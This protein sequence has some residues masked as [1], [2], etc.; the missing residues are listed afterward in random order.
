MMTMFFGLLPPYL[1]DGIFLIFSPPREGHT[2]A[3]VENISGGV[4]VKSDQQFVDLCLLICYSYK[5]EIPQF[6]SI[7]FSLLISYIFDN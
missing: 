2:W 7:L 4:M 6:P 5:F 3:F 1:G